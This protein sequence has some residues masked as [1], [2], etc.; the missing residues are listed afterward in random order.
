MIQ[1]TV[2]IAFH[3]EYMLSHKVVVRVYPGTLC[4]GFYPISC[5]EQNMKSMMQSIVF[6]DFVFF[7][8]N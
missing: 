1:Q 4:V 7:S 5:S 3:H 6:H 8:V 2:F